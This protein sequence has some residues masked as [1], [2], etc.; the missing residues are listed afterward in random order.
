VAHPL[1]MPVPLIQGEKK[2][3]VRMKTKLNKELIMLMKCGITETNTPVTISLQK[4]N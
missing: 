2:S 1:D 4:V 3:L